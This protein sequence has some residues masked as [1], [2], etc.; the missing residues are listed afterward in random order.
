MASIKITLSML[1][2]LTIFTYS[3]AKLRHHKETEMTLYYKDYA[4]GPN[5]TSIPI[6]GP[7]TGPLNFTMFGAMFVVDDPAVED[8]EDASAPII[9]RGRGVYII[10]ALDGSHAQLLMSVVFINGKY[11]GSTLEIQGS[12]AQFEPVAEAAVVGGTGK[13]R[14]ARGYATYEILS[15]DPV[16]GYSVTRSNITVL[17]Y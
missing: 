9:A 5:A 13:F 14:L 16:S 11:K 12:Y 3:Q 15:Y 10:S 17:H 6:P 2:F 7:S 8:I 1:L 4:G